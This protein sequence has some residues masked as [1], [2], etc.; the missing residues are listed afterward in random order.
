MVPAE[1]PVPVI[2]LPD[3]ADDLVLEDCTSYYDYY[4][5]W[6]TPVVFALCD[7]AGTA[8]YVPKAAKSSFNQ[9]SSVFN[10]ASCAHWQR[11]EG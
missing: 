3:P 11:G 1:L 6:C 10:Q 7:V 4:H 2:Q 8:A 5:V 9:A